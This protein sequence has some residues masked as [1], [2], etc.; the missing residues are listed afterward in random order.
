MIVVSV[1]TAFADRIFGTDKDVERL[2]WSSCVEP[3][4]KIVEQPGNRLNMVSLQK[5]WLAKEI[6]HSILIDGEADEITE[7]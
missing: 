2:V 5:F 4:L 3:G 1:V 6:A 7:D